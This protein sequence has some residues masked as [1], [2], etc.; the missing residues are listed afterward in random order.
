MLK[1][2]NIQFM[3]GNPQ[4]AGGAPPPDKKPDD[5]SDE[6]L[7]RIREFH[8]KPKE[9]RDYLDRFVIK[10]KEAKKVLS[11]ALCDHYNH[12][13]R[14][15]EDPTLREQ[16]YAKQ[17][18]IIMGPTG[19]GKT[20][21]VRCLARLIG[22]PFARADAT[23]FS[24]TGYVGYDV[25][26][27]VRDLVKMADGNTELAR[28][29]II[30]IDE[31]DK[32][33]ARSSGTSG[34]RDVSGRGVQI[35]LLKLMEETE[36]NL[37]SQTDLMGQVQAIMDMQQGNTRP[38]TIN[39]RHMLFIVS[40]AFDG[41]TDIIRRR[42]DRTAIGFRHEADRERP[43]LDYLMKA[44]AEDFIQ[45]GF[46]PEFIGRLPIR[47]ACEGLDEHD[48]ED[49]LVKS[50]ESILGQYIEDFK[51][52]GIDFKMLPDAIRHIASEASKEKT[53]A[54]GL[55]TVLERSLRE[56]KFELP[57][58]CV[59]H[60]EVNADTI[61]DTPHALSKIR[62][63]N[64][65]AH[66]A[67]LRDEVTAFK[68]R[69]QEEHGFELQFTDEAIDILVNLSLDTDKTIRAICEQKFR[70]FHHG[71]KLVASRTGDTVFEINKQT[72]EDPDK[73]LSTWVV[74]HFR[75][76]D[77]DKREGQNRE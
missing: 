20:Y 38:R 9:V 22:V 50:E 56:F 47:V 35:N 53:G 1:K 21:L 29:G 32:I 4:A 3:F 23:K 28:Y 54:R 26:D 69:F 7:R 14:C 75:H 19:V 67:L 30:Y 59:N 48:L 64:E 42:I 58:T 76:P 27:I 16:D 66:R 71:L 70:D 5:K 61:A 41:L 65:V 15:I 74:T 37:Q 43:E 63:E 11:V 52:Y 36:A 60:L 34:T 77:A 39:T 33:A 2:A 68:K 46:E 72:V 62:K 17:N 73:E 13:R 44:R 6:T 25:E 18:V 12:V 51:G 45:F 40:G 24:E 49:I 8:L 10:Q 31:I 55:M 57:S